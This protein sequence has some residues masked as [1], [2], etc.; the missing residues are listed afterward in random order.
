MINVAKLALKQFIDDGHYIQVVEEVDYLPVYKGKDFG[1]AW[2]AVKEY[3]SVSVE[4]YKTTKVYI[5]NMFIKDE[6]IFEYTGS[7]LEGVLE[8][9]YHA[10]ELS[11]KDWRYTL[12]VY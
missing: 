6:K 7:Y 10:T 8:G 9:I 1:K 11:E 12:G 3:K 2:K 4:V 5:G